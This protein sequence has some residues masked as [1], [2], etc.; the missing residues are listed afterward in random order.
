MNARG[1]YTSHM[2]INRILSATHNQVLLFERGIKSD[3]CA[4]MPDKIRSLLRG[5]RPGI[6]LWIQAQIHLQACR[7]N[8]NSS[9]GLRPVTGRGC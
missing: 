8:F 7:Q 1:F 3:Q 9:E 6:I 4:H 2:N 5:Q